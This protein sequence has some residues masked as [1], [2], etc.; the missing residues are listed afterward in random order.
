MGMQWVRFPPQLTEGGII[1]VRDSPCRVRIRKVEVRNTVIE[2]AWMYLDQLGP[3][4]RGISRARARRAIYLHHIS[5][6]V[7]PEVAVGCGFT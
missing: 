5:G 7:F 2:Y 1:G 3:G 4:A 6:V